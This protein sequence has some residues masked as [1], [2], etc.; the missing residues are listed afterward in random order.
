MVSLGF[1]VIANAL[2]GAVLS[3][4]KFA[5]YY[6]QVPVFFDK[7]SDLPLI[8]DFYRDNLLSLIH[9]YSPERVGVKKSEPTSFQGRALSDSQRIQLYSEGMAIST[10][11]TFGIRCNDYCMNNINSIYGMKVNNIK[12]SDIVAQNNL[13]HMYDAECV[14]SD[15]YFRDALAV[16]L[17]CQKGER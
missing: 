5:L 12:I 8:L 17:C 1:R 9:E 6:F 15:D 3:G 2:Y 16:A 13:S 10:V 14:E 7:K 4:E 11:G